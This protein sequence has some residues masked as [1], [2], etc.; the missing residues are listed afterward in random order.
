MMARLAQLPTLRIDPSQ[1]LSF[2]YRGKTY[3]GLKGDTVA[4]ALYAQGTR[5][6]SRSIKYHRPR[7]LYSLDGECANA[8]MDVDGVPNV[9]AERTLLKEGM[10]VSPQNV[11][12]SPEWDLQ[13]FTD[14]LSWAMPA[15][16]YYRF[17]HKPYKLWPFFLSQ[18]RKAAGI[19]V[20]H[21]TS[22]LQGRFDERYLTGDVCVIGGGPAGITAAL[23]AAQQGLRVILLE[24]RP[25]LGGF[26]DYRVAENGQHGP[27]FKRGRELASRL[28]KEARVRVFSHTPLIGFYNNNHLTAFQVGG[29][30]DPFDERYMEIRARSVVVATGCLERPLLFENND[31]PGVMQI[32]CAHRLART[33]GLLPGSCAVFSIGHDLGLEAAMDLNDLGQDISCVADCRVTG[34]D[35]QLIEALAERKIPVLRGWVASMAHGKTL[36]KVT[37]TTTEGRKSWELNCDVLVA[38]AGLTPLSGPLS[39]A[40]ATM[41]YDGHTG[42][43]LPAELPANVHA[44]GRVLGFHHPE[45][46]EASGRLAGLAAAAD[47]GVAVESALRETQE[48]LAQCPGPTQG[49]K[50]V[51]APVRGRKAFLCFDEDTTLK[52]IYQACDMG[53]DRVELA[54]R[55]TAAGT[56]PCQGGI[57]GHNLPLFMS[58]YVGDPSAPE[59][60]STVRPPLVTTLM[61]TYAGTHRDLFKRTPLHHVQEKEGAVFRRI[62]AWKR[63]RYFSQDFT[64]RQEIENVRNNV[65]I[66]DVSTLGKF[67]LFGPDSLKVLQRVY[68]SDMARISEGK[69][70]YSALC[71]EDGC[72]LDDGVVV[73]RDE[74]DYYL[75]SSTARADSTVEWF[76]YHT[77]YEDWDYC[78]VNLTDAF[79]AINLAGPNARSVLRKLTDADIAN[80]AFPYAAYREMILAD[81][82]PARVMRLG[83]LG[84]L[85]FEIHVPASYTETLWS[86]LLEAG[87]EYGLRPFGVEAQNVLRLE[88]GHV[89]IG[90]ESEIRTTLHD[91]GLSFL[92]SR[93]K[94]EAKTVGAPALQF[95]EPQQGRLKLVGLEMENPYRPPKDGSIVV[96]T[97]IRGYVATARFS[98]PLQK[99]VALALVEDPLAKPG[100]RL[101]VFEDGMGKKRLYATVV[102]IPFYDPE[103]KRLKM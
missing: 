24:A 100:T 40:R 89:I 83:F 48:R 96:D 77:R 85:S 17:F 92:W 27:L 39:L 68:V 55:F 65:G 101:A 32:A 25:W 44:A 47:C 30:T 35:P 7:G 56:G 2:T 20:I 5:I 51:Q 71:N 97:A 61:A 79:G 63:A 33:W 38:S 64:C 11:V 42:F 76:R 86:L 67:R 91:L 84:E 90:Q 10:T 50:L 28:K 46:I 57:P 72:L 14:K 34:Q 58:Q 81:H 4:T 23:A 87:R 12:G 82:I 69:V 73:K 41:R 94:K 88:K 13:G 74:N 99:A 70:K 98:Y 19:G 93:R 103:G 95:T 31:R 36:K 102:P 52:H 8:L 29:G 43:F 53:F 15:G 66:I 54:K 45:S 18:I 59:L 22:R 16:F 1:P 75:T 80:Q 3:Q 6:F 49:S 21:P 62:G 78:L 60:P 26:F 9:R 37:L